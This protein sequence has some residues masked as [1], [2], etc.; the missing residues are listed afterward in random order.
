MAKERKSTN[1]TM[2]QDHRV[3]VNK[4]V[5]PSLEVGIEVSDPEDFC[6]HSLS[7]TWQV[8]NYTTEE[9][10]LELSFAKTECVSG[11]TNEGDELVVTFYA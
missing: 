6:A 2:I 4:T 5:Y 11:S 10:T 3:F 1:Y 9:L 7:F 8:S